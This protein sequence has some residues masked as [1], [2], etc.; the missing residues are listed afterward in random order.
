[1]AKNVAKVAALGTQHAQAP[2][3]FG[4][5]VDQVGEGQARWRGQRVLQVFV[6]LADDLQV[7]G[8]HQRIALGGFGPVNQAL[9]K[10]AVP[11]HVKLEPERR[12]GVG[13]NVFN[14][15]DAHGRQR[16]RHAKFFGRTGRQNFAVG[17]LHARHAHGGQRHRHG[18]VAPHHLRAGAAAVDIDR[19]ALAQLDA[20]KIR[21]VGAV[22]AF[23]PGARVAVVVKHAR[24][25]FLV[26]D[27]QI[28]NGGDN[29]HRQAFRG[30]FQ[31]LFI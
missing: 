27:A 22:G 6:A 23:G 29:G 28:F 10:T 24:H 15:A 2:G 7:E 20:L 16:E 12:F 5:H 25:A 1:M 4:G 8:Q 19:H 18:H 31:R 30:C 26:Q 13:G 14:G 9:Y 11:H 3:R 17:V 21:R